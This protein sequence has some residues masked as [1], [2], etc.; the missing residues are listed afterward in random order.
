MVNSSYVG[1]RSRRD[2]GRRPAMFPVEMWSMHRRV[3]I[4]TNRTNN[5]AE[6]AHRRFKAELGTGHPTIWKLNESLRKVQHSRDLIYEQLDKEGC[7]G[8]V[9]TDLEVPA[10]NNRKD[11]VENCRVG[12]QWYQ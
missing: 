3:V 5:Y 9:W 4:E 11:H 1:R 12:P 7:R 2:G 10:R 6:A 8:A